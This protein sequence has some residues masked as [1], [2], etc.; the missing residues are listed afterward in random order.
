[1]RRH[2]L[3][4]EELNVANEANPPEDASPLDEASWGAPAPPP[5][6]AF[7]RPID[8][9]VNDLE[10]AAPDL[11]GIMGALVFVPIGTDRDGELA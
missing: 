2:Y 8:L 11:I 4:V 7:V 10:H 1:M 3:E 5:V 9:L 6:R